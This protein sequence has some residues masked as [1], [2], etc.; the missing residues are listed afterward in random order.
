LTLGN[1]LAHQGE[2]EAAQ[3]A[4]EAAMKRHQLVHSDMGRANALSNIGNVRFREQKFDDAHKAYTAALEIY[5]Q[6]EVPWVRRAPSAIS[7]MCCS[8]RATTMQ[9]SICMSGA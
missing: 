3:K 2:R 9:L 7:A 1:I 6:I 4:C 5:R 8:A